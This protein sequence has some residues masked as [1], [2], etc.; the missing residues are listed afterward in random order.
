MAIPAD[1]SKH[2]AKARVDLCDFGESPEKKST[3]VRVVFDITAGEFAGNT[4]QWDGWFSEKAIE[5]TLQSLKYC[6]CTFPG[7]DITNLTGIDTNE[8]EIVLSHED[9][10]DK[11]GNQRTAVKVAFVNGGARGVNPDQ[12]L[13]TAKKAAFRAKMLGTVANLNQ[14]SGTVNG[15]PTSAGGGDNI[16][17]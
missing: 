13:D 6:G 8:V 4:Y 9:Y 15:K 12:L 17:F 10:T 11:E 3:Y 5:R 14:K 7:N 16:P 1:K 2:K